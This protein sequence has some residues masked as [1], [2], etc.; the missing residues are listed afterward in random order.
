MSSYP[1]HTT[2]TAPEGGRQALKG[3][4]QAFGLVPN[5]AATM[6]NSPP[7]VNAFVAAFGQ[8]HGGTF[9]AGERQMLLLTNAVA[10]KSA[11]AV[12]FHS[13]LALKEGVDAAD[14]EAVRQHGTPAPLRLAALST[15]TRTLI[16]KR[17]HLDDGDVKVFIAAGFD[18]HQVLE[19]ITGVAI[20]A[21][22]N[23]TGN[24]ARPP[25]E[26]P[27]QAQA[28]SGGY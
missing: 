24:V 21:M 10:N 1:I 16:D 28:W 3:L 13:T 19:V 11:W 2:E 12:A 7:L 5:L 6:A 23:Y 15:L 25:V 18:D 22:A 9:T 14:V 8:F 26:E 4:E 17:G 20:S 27:F